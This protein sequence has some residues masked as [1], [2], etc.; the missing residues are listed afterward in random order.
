MRYV[1]VITS[2]FTIDLVD[3]PC[4]I[5]STAS[6]SSNSGCVGRTPLA[7]KLSGVGTIGFPKTWCHTRLTHTRA[8]S[9]LRALPID[10]A[11]TSRP[12]PLLILVS[13]S[14]M[15]TCKYPRGTVSPG[16]SSSPR[17]SNRAFCG[18][19]DSCTPIARRLASVGL[20]LSSNRASK[21]AAASSRPSAVRARCSCCCSAAVSFT[22]LPGLRASR[23]LAM[24][25][26][27][28]SASVP[29]RVNCAST[30]RRMGPGMVAPLG[31]SAF[32][33]NSISVEG[34][35]LPCPR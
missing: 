20:P 26:F 25:A 34:W 18:F 14:C 5:K 23:A 24:S 30:V 33:G 7:P 3:H 12:L 27:A 31:T 16:F 8:V 32:A 13:P 22:V 29:A 17:E 15:R 9:G 1:C 19:S 21:S 35:L 28:C 6:Q 4:S 10:C 2:D 11:N